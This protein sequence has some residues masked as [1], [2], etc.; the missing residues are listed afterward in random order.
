MLSIYGDRACVRAI[1]AHLCE[2]SKKYTSH[3]RI[4]SESLAIDPGYQTITQTIGP[5]KLHIIM[6][7]P[8][9]TH[10]WSPFKDWFLVVSPNPEDVFYNRLNRVCPVP[11]RPQWKHTLWALGLA[12]KLITPLDGFG[13]PGY[14]VKASYDLWAN[15]VKEAITEGRLS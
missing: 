4:G 8:A 5:Q 2:M 10:Q 9:T 15:C 3:A 14:K 7:H 12:H 1:W 11:F 13:M 6:L